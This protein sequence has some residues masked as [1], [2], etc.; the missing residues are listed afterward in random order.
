MSE[1]YG[2]IGAALCRAFVLVCAAVLVLT[3]T[4]ALL[5]RAGMPFAGAYTGGVL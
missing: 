1:R 5:T 4:A 3:A 2:W